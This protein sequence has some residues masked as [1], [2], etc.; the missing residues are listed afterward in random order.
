[1]SVNITCRAPRGGVSFAALKGSRRHVAARVETLETRTVPLVNSS[2]ASGTLTIVLGSG[3]D[4]ATVSLA[5][6]N[7]DVFDGT[8]HADFAKP[9]LRTS[10][11]RATT[12]PVRASPSTATSR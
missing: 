7:I 2:L 6:G 9:A 1:M 3:G 8:K 11:L 10:V 12:H 5:S 4:A